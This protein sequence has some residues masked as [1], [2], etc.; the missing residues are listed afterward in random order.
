MD[1]LTNPSKVR[2]E[3]S[4]VFGAAEGERKVVNLEKMKEYMGRRVESYQERVRIC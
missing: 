3:N 4:M 1:P 2:E